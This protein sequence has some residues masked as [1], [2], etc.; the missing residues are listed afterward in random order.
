MVQKTDRQIFSIIEGLVSR[1]KQGLDLGPNPT[2]T[3][4]ERR[5]VAV[6]LRELA[7]MVEVQP[8]RF[9]AIGL[10]EARQLVGVGT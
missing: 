6:R 3:R 1:R 5:L 9:K 4:V 8:E 2:L 10:E 7:T